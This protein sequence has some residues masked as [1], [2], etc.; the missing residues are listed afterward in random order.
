MKKHILQ[1]FLMPFLITFA[2]GQTLKLDSLSNKYL[3]T[4]TVFVDSIKKDILFLK[5]KEWIALNYKSANDVIQLADKETCKIILKGAFSTSM[6]MK[7]GWLEHTL[8]LDFKDGKF[9]YSYTDFSYYSSGSGKMNFESKSLGFKK[10]IFTKTEENI[11]SSIE[12][13]KRYFQDYIKSKDW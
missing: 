9:K 2:F 5:A 1:L 13:L 12:S 6:F 4:G 8:V 11:S 10:K 3:S 7:E